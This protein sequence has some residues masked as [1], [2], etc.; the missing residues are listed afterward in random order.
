L[1]APTFDAIRGRFATSAPA[2]AIRDS[3]VLPVVL[4]S[5][6]IAQIGL[7]SIAVLAGCSAVPSASPPGVEQTIHVLE[8]DTNVTLVKVGSLTGCTTE[9]CEGDYYVGDNSLVDAQTRKLVGNFLFECFVV[10]VA[11]GL[12]HCPSN[13][14]VL[15]GRGRIVIT[16]DVYIGNRSATPGP[17]PII[18]GTGEFLGVTGMMTSPPNSTAPSGDFIVTYTR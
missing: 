6:R 5:R 2:T 4:A 14:M 9:V 1:I 11:S 15:T 10:D 12:Y 13:T 3:E 7:L 8:V 16:E 18:G 17:W